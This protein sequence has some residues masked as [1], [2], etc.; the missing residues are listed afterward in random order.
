MMKKVSTHFDIEIMMLIGKK[1]A[2]KKV[3][4]YFNKRLFYAIMLVKY[5][6]NPSKQVLIA[7]KFGKSPALSN[8]SAY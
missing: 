5:Y 8:T 7:S 1:L 2:I 3:F 4:C 6:F